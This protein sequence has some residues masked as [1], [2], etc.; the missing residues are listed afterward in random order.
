MPNVKLLV[1]DVM[2]T[3]AGGI[4]HAGELV[5]H[6]LADVADLAIPTTGPRLLG[7]ILGR[8]AILDR[9]GLDQELVLGMVQSR[10][11]Q[12]VVGMEEDLLVALDKENTDGFGSTGTYDALIGPDQIPTGLGGFDLVDFGEGTGSKNIG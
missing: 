7:G 1:V 3:G 2:P 8:E 6:F 9:A 4:P 11:A 10:L 12:P 5:G